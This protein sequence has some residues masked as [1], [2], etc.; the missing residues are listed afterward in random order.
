M[1]EQARAAAEEK[2]QAARQKLDQAAEMIIEK[3]V[4]R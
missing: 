2:K 1:T 4:S 3:V